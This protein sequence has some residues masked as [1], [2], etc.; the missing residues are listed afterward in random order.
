MPKLEFLDR[1]EEQ[2]ALLRQAKAG[3]GRSL[4]VFVHGFRGDHLSTWGRLPEMLREHA[5]A[6]PVLARWDF[7][8]IGY[9]TRRIASYLDIARLIATQWEKA[10]AGRPPFAGAY[11]RLALLG[12]SLGTLGIRQLLCAAVMQPPRMLEALHSVTLFGT[13]L[14]GSTLALF[15]GA[16]I[17]G[18]IAEA[19]KPGNAQLRMLRVWSDSVHPLL[20]WRKVRLVLGTDDQVVGNEYADLID[21]AGDARPAALLNFDHGDLVKPRQWVESAIRDEI[22]GALR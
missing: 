6:D 13:P 10:A 8:F 14:N 5:Q 17:G 3:A 4:A 7:L 16:L 22:V 20:Q 21:F 15:G 1:Q 9:P 2:W 19:L 11:G 18:E 12:H